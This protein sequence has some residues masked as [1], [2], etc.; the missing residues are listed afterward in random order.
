MRKIASVICAIAVMASCEPRGERP[1]LLFDGLKGNIESV[2]TR[3]YDEAGTLLGTHT[4][5]YTESGQVLSDISV[6]GDGSPETALEYKYGESGL[7]EVV[8]TDGPSGY[9]YHTTKDNNPSNRYSEIHRTW[10]QD[11]YLT[12]Y[13]YV[14]RGVKHFLYNRYD[15]KNNLIST[16]EGDDRSNPSGTVTRY[17]Y[18][19]FDAEGNWTV[20]TSKT[21]G[22]VT[23]M[24]REISYR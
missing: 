17:R 8:Q 3:S 21:G 9:V 16:K 24:E 22:T 7:R 6:S 19:S 4:V 10:N 14:D 23:R 2:V 11:G 18:S 13:V 12:S 15:R 5:S 1:E 20:G